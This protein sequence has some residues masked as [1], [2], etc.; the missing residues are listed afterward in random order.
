MPLVYLEASRRGKKRRP[1]GAT[2]SLA[3]VQSFLRKIR[4]HKTCWL[5]MGALTSNGYA[6]FQSGRGHR[7][8]YEL[9][10]GAIPADKQLDHLCRVRHCVNPA[11]LEAVD[12]RTNILRGT[13]FSAINHRKKRCSNG[14]LFDKTI[15]R[16]SGVV[17]RA[18]RRCRRASY[19]SMYGKRRAEIL[20]NQKR[21]YQKNRAVILAQHRKRYWQLKESPLEEP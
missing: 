1:H 5:W 17:E 13:G 9:F 21:R 3:V 18:C 16:V 14:H 8:V 4:P 2:A 19:L 11:H 7:F 10:H 20:A 12:Q 6:S 15:Y